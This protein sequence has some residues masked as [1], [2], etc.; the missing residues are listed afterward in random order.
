AVWSRPRALPLRVCD[1]WERRRRARPRRATRVH[2]ARTPVTAPCD[3]SHRP[4][5]PLLP[6][7]GLGPAAADLDRPHPGV[8][9][10][11]Q[12]QG[13]DT[14]VVLGAGVLRI[15][16]ARQLHHLAELLAGHAAP[17]AAGPFRHGALSLA[18]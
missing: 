17:D 10:L 9:G 2:E 6:L 4:L 7:D 3:L 12:R 16:V 18:L 1:L 13:R 8:L 15:D 5:L 11:G 14:V